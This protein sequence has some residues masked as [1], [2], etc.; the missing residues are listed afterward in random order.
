MA[1]V[2]GGGL[3]STALARCGYHRGEYF[4]VHA[5][6]AYDAVGADPAVADAQGPARLG[7]SGPAA[8]RLASLRLSPGRR[9][10]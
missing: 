2:A 3:V 8:A 7:I 9:V 1:A 6:A 4:T 5:Q 10:I